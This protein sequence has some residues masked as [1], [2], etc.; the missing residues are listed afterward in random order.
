MTG[1]RMPSGSTQLPLKRSRVEDERL[2]G[3]DT[4][5]ERREMGIEGSGVEERRG[6]ALRLW[7]ARRKFSVQLRVFQGCPQVAQGNGLVKE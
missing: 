3:E 6:R 1:E 5:D 2:S 4:T 7:Q